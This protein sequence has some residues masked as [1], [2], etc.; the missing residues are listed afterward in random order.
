MMISPLLL[1]KVDGIELPEIVQ[2]VQKRTPVWDLNRFSKLTLKSEYNI[3]TQC[4]SWK[5]GRH[6]F[7]KG[8]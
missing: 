1:A 3:S 5:Q 4:L 7:V 8:G 6:F 2:I